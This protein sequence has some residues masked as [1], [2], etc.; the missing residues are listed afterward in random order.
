MNVLQDTSK[1]G[2]WVWVLSLLSQHLLP[3]SKTI[4]KLSS[5]QHRKSNTTFVCNNLFFFNVYLF[6]R[7]RE[8]EHERGRVR[9]RGR[10]RIR[11]RLQA[12]SCQHRAQRRA[13]T[14]ELRDHD[15]SR[16]RTLNQLSHLGAPNSSFYEKWNLKTR[17]RHPLSYHYIRTSVKVVFQPS[18]ITRKPNS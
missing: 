3:K 6:L 15:L 16:S 8:T 4:L 11:S 14:H 17:L 18:N 7:Q 13:R 2:K 1:R 9:E 10:H 12:L 5:S